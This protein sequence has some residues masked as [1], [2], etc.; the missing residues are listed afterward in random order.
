MNAASREKGK[1]ELAGMD[2]ELLNAAY[3]DARRFLRR[4]Y[5]T[6]LSIG[7]ARRGGQ[8]TDELA[9]CVHVGNKLPDSALTAAQRLPRSIRGVPVDVVQVVLEPQFVDGAEGIARRETRMNPVVPGLQIKT[10]HQDFGTI[11]LV[12]RRQ[13]A[14][15]STTVLLTAGHVLGGIG[16]RVFQPNGTT[17][18][19]AVGRV[20]DMRVSGIDAGCVGLAGRSGSNIP[21]DTGRM[22]AGTRSATINE[23]L[24]MSGAYA[25]LIQGVVRGPG[26]LKTIFSGGLVTGFYLNPVP[27]TT[28]FTEKGDSG[29]LWFDDS[30]HAVGLHVAGGFD[31][32]KA[33]AFACDIGQVMQILG[34]Q[35]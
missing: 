20:L 21:F 32:G 27:G 31:S 11:G 23:R 25:G 9:I 5:V 15:A 10:E 33:W 2:D 24:S 35:F 4:S 7:Y 30:G 26:E 22:V 18:A 28:G 16:V 13:S 29:S 34:L 19:N 8:V 1:R 6:G 17:S 3:M 14:G 12:A